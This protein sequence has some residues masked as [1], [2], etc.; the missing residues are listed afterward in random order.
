MRLLNT[1]TLELRFFMPSAVPDY[2]ILSHRWNV[3]TSEECTLQDMTNTP[4]S[5]PESP[6][7]KKQGFQKIEGACRLARKYE[8]NW[9]WIDTCCI[10][11]SSSAELQEAINSMWRY[12]AEANIC[13]VYMA[14]VRAFVR[15]S[16]RWSFRKSEWFSRGW[17]LQELVAPVIVEFYAENWEPVGTKLERYEEIAK[18][19]GISTA[20]LVRSREFDTFSA[21]EKLSWAAHRTVTRSEDEAYSLWGL[22]QVNMPLLYGEGRERAFRRLQEA[23]YN[24]TTDHS[25]FLFRY[26]F[27]HDSQ[28]L[29][30]DS[31]TRF[32]DR[33][34]RECTRWRTRELQTSPCLP[35]DVNYT[36]IVSSRVRQTQP[37]EQIITN[38]TSHG[39]EITTTLPLLPWKDVYNKLV[40]FG[41]APDNSLMISHVA[42]LNHTLS[43]YP[44]GAF[45]ILLEMSGNNVE[46]FQRPLI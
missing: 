13:Y 26:S 37:H 24:T 5:N 3:Q 14:D 1:E 9:I 44:T 30:A 22:F 17:T 46:A 38:V 12:Y 31:P 4:I 20:V 43:N 8:Y 25:L 39:S 36:D 23:I 2:V 40:F 18:I 7:R 35:C 6:A 21:A 45:C 28:P 29:L 42:V 32:C 16:T 11:K 10:D 41:K 34:R 19:T 33:S 27:H 15:G